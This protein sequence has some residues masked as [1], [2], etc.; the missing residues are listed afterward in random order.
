MYRLED[1]QFE[2]LVAY[3]ELSLTALSDEEF[4]SLLSMEEPLRDM[5]LTLIPA[6]D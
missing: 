2:A 5:L 6:P 1:E 4:V 3:F